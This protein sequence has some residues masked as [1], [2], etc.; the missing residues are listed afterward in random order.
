MWENKKIPVWQTLCDF[1]F[2]F[3]SPN[4]WTS[5][6]INS[7]ISDRSVTN[8]ADASLQWRLSGFKLWLFFL[9]ISSKIVFVELNVRW[10]NVNLGQL[11]QEA[12]CSLPSVSSGCGLGPCVL[13]SRVWLCDPM[14]CSPPGSSVHGDSP[15]QNS[16][17]GCHALLQ[18]IFPTQGLNPGLSHCRQILYH[19][20]HQGSPWT[21]EWAAYPFS[22]GSSRPGNP[23]LSLA[24]QDSLPAEL[25]RK[26]QYQNPRMLKFLIWNHFMQSALGN[27][28]L[29]VC[30]LGT[31]G[32]LTV[33]ENF[34]L[35]CAEV[36]EV[37]QNDLWMSL[38]FTCFDQTLLLI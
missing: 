30:G 29:V 36:W 25:A 28:W 27:P 1:H 26:P 12:R 14:D 34:T 18:G 5:T 3:F 10:W 32:Q 23:K 2:L 17:V 6:D 19:L 11:I 22:K 24:L 9:Y 8:V 4:C 15:G 7:K 20:N 16:G 37:R 33:L 21:L 38:S 35:V 13:L 31:L